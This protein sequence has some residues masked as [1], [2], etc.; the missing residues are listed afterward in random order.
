MQVG[1][2][3]EV[4]VIVKRADDTVRLDTGFFPNVIT[5][6]GLD[7]IGND[8][9][10]FNYCAV[11]GGNSKP[12]NTNTKLDNFLAVGSQISSE[13][14]YDYDPVR[15]TEFY[16]CSRTVG[17]RFEGLDNKNISEVGL[18][19]DYAS[20]QHP[21]YTR[22]LIKN[23]AGEPTVI[24]VL[25]GEILE[26]QYRLWQVFDVKDK[27]QVVTAMIDGV[28]V[29]FN[30]KIR[31]AGVGGNLGGSW[32]YAAVVGAHLTFQGNNYHQFGTGELGEITGQNSGG[33]TNVYGLS[34]EAYQ[35]STYKRKFYVNAS[36][37]DAVHPIRSFLF[38]TGLGAYQVR[39]GTVNGDLPIDKT[40]QDILQLGFEMSWGRYEGV[41]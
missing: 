40:N 26:L 35:P 36:I 23:S 32:S 37:T 10:L 15:D 30:V 1:L 11:G 3:G 17:Y 25:S 22:T 6:L 7:A 16:K 24:T 2:Y 19:G 28:E 5:N 21:A 8:N 38:F 13:S 9:D 27:D 20:G 33:L 39:F 41:I 34:W 18:V 29:P 14:K 12:L 31:L 4:K